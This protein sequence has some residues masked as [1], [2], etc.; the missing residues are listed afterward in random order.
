VLEWI[1]DQPRLRRLVVIV[2]TTSTLSADKDRAYD[3]GTNAYLTK[4]MDTDGLAQLMKTLHD[5]WVKFNECPN[6]HSA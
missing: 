5:F 1:Q 6:C 4:P 2:F 3:L